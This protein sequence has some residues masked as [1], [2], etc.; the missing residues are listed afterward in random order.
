MI[1]N[2]FVIVWIPCNIIF[3][4]CFMCFVISTKEE[5]FLINKYSPVLKYDRAS[6]R[7]ASICKITYFV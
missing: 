4:I 3:T 5:S 2:M 7:C 6:Y 1:E